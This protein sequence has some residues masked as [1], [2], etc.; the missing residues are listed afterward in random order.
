VNR[1]EPDPFLTTSVLGEPSLD[2]VTN[3]LFCSIAGGIWRMNHKLVESRSTDPPLIVKSL[4]PESI[5]GPFAPVHCTCS[6]KYIL[7]FRA[8]SLPCL[9]RLRSLQDSGAG[10][11][12]H[13]P[14]RI[15]AQSQAHE[16]MTYLSGF[17]YLDI[18][19][20]RMCI[21]TGRLHQG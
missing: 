4:L 10:R 11:A 8:M 15:P 12:A 2:R 1:R 7:S 3:L 19:V 13:F 20:Y 14:F 18:Q 16:T 6:Q 21:F 5:G 17:S 9:I